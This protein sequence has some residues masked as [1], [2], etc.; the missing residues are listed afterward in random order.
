VEENRKPGEV[1]MTAGLT[2]LPYQRWLKTDYVS[3]D[4]V[5]ALDRAAVNGGYLLHT[6]P[7]FLE[8]RLP[9]LAAEVKRRGSEVKRFPGTLGGGDVV[10]IAFSAGR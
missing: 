3:I 4:S 10:V 6:L 1:V 7:T 5:A 8:S 2:D 9:E